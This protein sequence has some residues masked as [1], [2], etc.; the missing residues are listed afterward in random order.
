[1]GP[2]QA[3]LEVQ[4]TFNSILVA[5]DSRTLSGRQMIE[6]LIGLLLELQ[7]KAAAIPLNTVQIW[8]T[9]ILQQQVC[10]LPAQ[11]QGL[12][13]LPVRPLLSEGHSAAHPV[14]PQPCNLACADS[15]AACSQCWQAH[16]HPGP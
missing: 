11:L 10:I 5:S 2:W 6:G 9:S 15:Q 3:M 16:Q 7:R 1:M 12:I 13:G 8:E 14:R 4:E